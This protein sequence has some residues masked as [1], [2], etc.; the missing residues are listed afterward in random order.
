VGPLGAMP[1]T[2]KREQR[3]SSIHSYSTSHYMYVNCQLHVPAALGPG[4]TPAHAIREAGKGRTRCS[5]CAEEKGALHLLGT[6]HLFLCSLARCLVTTELSRP[7]SHTIR[8]IN[9]QCMRSRRHPGYRK[10]TISALS[11]SAGT[12]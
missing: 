9:L 4:L 6:K 7:P 3:L 5:S 10:V 1:E 2:C 12:R 11:M 8:S